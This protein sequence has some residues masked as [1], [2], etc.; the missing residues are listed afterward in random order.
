MGAK[1]GCMPRANCRVMPLESDRLNQVD[2]IILD[3]LRDEGQATPAILEEVISERR[4]E[5]VSRSY[6]NQRLVR[7]H[8][9]GHI[10][11]VRDKGVYELVEDPRT[12]LQK[13][14]IPLRVV[15]HLSA[16]DRGDARKIS[17]RVI[18]VGRML[19]DGMEEDELYERAPVTEFELYQ[20]LNSFPEMDVEDYFDRLLDAD[21]SSRFENIDAEREAEKIPKNYDVAVALAMGGQLEEATEVMELLQPI[22]PK[23]EIDSADFEQIEKLRESIDGLVEQR[24][25]LEMEKR[26]EELRDKFKSVLNGE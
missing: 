18:R 7:L 10:E 16:E 21:F 3:Y 26:R 14:E 4:D 2:H 20:T 9:H 5:S 23:K 1:L 15:E 11:N 6:I 12:L 25:Q 19:F 22:G 13:Y 24:L 8:E 17:E